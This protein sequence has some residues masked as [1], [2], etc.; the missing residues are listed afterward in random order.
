[1]GGKAKLVKRWSTTNIL[2]EVRFE[3]IAIAARARRF[4]RIPTPR[5]P[6]SSVALI[7]LNYQHWHWRCGHNSLLLVSLMVKRDNGNTVRTL[8]Q[9]PKRTPYLVPPLSKSKK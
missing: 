1:M 6:V 5:G 8:G 4:G 3:S 2:L 7:C 9:L